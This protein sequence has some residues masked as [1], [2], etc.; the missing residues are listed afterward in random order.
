MPRKRPQTATF[1]EILAA[2]PPGPD[3][4]GEHEEGDRDGLPGQAEF[5]DARGRRWRLV[6]DR[7]DP[8]AARRL[9]GQ[10]DVLL[11]GHWLHEP[12]E[13]PPERRQAFWQS[14]RRRLYVNDPDGHEAHEYASADGTVLL[15]VTE[16]C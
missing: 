11:A 6:R 8:R 16:Y 9:V 1:A 4:A 12:E 15:C 2:A 10:A 13:I 3:Q 5:V 14:V 7:L